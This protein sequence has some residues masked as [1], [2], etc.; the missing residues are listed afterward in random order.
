MKKY[1]KRLIRLIFDDRRSFSRIIFEESVLPELPKNLKTLDLGCGDGRY[2]PLFKNYIGV[3]L[4]PP[5]GKKFIKE[6]ARKLSFRNNSF[7]FIFCTALIEHLRDYKK[8]LS[9]IK[10][11]LKPG[12]LLLISAP[13][14]AGLKFERLKVY[15]GFWLEDLENELEKLGLKTLKTW[16]LTKYPLMLFNRLPVRMKR[17]SKLYVLIN[18]ILPGKY[19]GFAIYAKL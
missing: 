10:R 14:P 16:K 15:R 19:Q 3:D 4:N 8:V 17:L 11:V 2:A 5:Q 9:E 1:I 6:D 13:T 7:E 18:K 12:G